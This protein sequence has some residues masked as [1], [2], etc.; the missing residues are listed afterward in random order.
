MALHNI[1]SALHV[2]IHFII[3]ATLLRYCVRIPAT[4]HSSQ[5]DAHVGISW[6]L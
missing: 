6:N 5:R 2:S 1:L 4:P 3:T